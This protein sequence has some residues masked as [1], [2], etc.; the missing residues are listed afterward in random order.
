MDLSRFQQFFWDEV[1]RLQK[2]FGLPLIVVILIIPIIIFCILALIF[3]VAASENILPQGNNSSDMTYLNYDANTVIIKNTSKADSPP[4][5]AELAQ[6]KEERAKGLM[7]RKQLGTNNGMLFIFPEPQQVEFWMMNTYISLD[8]IF[9][10]TN[11]EIIN[12]AKNTTPL[13]TTITYP[14]GGSVKYVLE[15]N[16]GFTDKYNYSVGDKLSIEFTRP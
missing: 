4:I 13:D 8:M 11:N 7:S 16:A 1:R 14:S 3:I 2:V 10:T 12:I 6:T 9:I 15:V 5:T